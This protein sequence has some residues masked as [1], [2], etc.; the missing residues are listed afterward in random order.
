VDLTTITAAYNGLKVGREILNA[1]MEAKIETEARGKI[2]EVVTKL[3]AAQDTMF[4][5]REELFKL[6]SENQDLRRKSAEQESWDKRLSAYSLKGT[7]GGAV[8]YAANAEPLHYICPSC[9]NKRELHI[10]QDNRTA[11]GK[12]RCTG[13]ESE[14]PINRRQDA[15]KLDYPDN[16]VV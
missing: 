4:E 9:L 3:G 12:F 13:C 10:L 14:Y 2:L 6:Q 15:S 1:F 5:M 16:G 11:S 7:V 8:V